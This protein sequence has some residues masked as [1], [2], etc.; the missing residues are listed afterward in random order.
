MLKGNLD[1]VVQHGKR[2]D[3]IVKNMLL[4]SREGSGEH[5][6]VDQR[7][8]RGE[9]EPRL[10]RRARREAGFNITLERDL[11]SGGRRGRPLS[12][13]DHAGA[14]QPD[15][16]RLLRDDEAPD[17]DRTAAY[18][19]MLAASTQDLGDSVEIRIRDNGTGIP[20]NVKER[21]S[22]RSSRPSRRARAPALGFAQP[23]HRREAARRHDRG[24]HRARRFTE[25]RI[26]LPRGGASL[27][28]PHKPAPSQ[29][30]R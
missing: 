2:A 28:R 8:G 15:L 27:G 22:I 10:S 25:F 3:S 19:P 5:R 23:R 29:G 12:A 1:K 9:P 17:A 20:P 16:Q 11:R 21:C 7:H 24:R 26:V 13:G 4:H 30:Q 6:P 14:A 18:E